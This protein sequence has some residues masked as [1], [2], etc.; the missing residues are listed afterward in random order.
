MFIHLNIS[1]M[2]LFPVSLYIVCRRFDPPPPPFP[3]PLYRKPALW[4]GSLFIFS[5]NQ[6]LLKYG[7][8]TKILKNRI[9]TKINS[10]GKVFS[11]FL[12]D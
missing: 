6:P 11:S 10:C 7:I 8:N 4:P 9:S 5:P 12:E 2:T 1:N 3:L